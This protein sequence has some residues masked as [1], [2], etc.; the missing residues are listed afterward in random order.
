MK[1]EEGAVRPLLTIA[2]PTYNRAK[3]LAGLLNVLLPQVADEPR[4]ELLICD[5]ASPDETEAVVRGWM[6]GGAPVRYIRHAENIGSDANF[7]RCFEE[8]RGEYFWLFGDDDVVLPGTV[9]KVLGHLERDQWDML[10]VTGYEFKEDYERERVEDKLG[11]RWHTIENERELMRVVNVMFTLI[12]VIVVNKRR[13]E[14]IAHEA[15]RELVGTNLVQLSWSLPLL[16]H[17]RK[18]L[19][20]WERM[21]AGRLGNAGGYSVGKVFG[22]RLKEVAERTMPGRA[23]LVDEL[24]NCTL[25]R[26]FPR[27]LY[28][29]RAAGNTRLG[30]HEVGDVLEKCFGRNFR[31]W[32][33]VYPVL[34]LPMNMAKMWVKAGMAMSHAVYMLTV[35][36]FWSK[37]R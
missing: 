31:Y 5:N 27:T 30:M 15:P 18:S 13:L 34:K 7:V 11:R 10:Y 6:E 1:S 28:E 33:F 26:W 36:R 37:E 4:V 20:V 3:L 2:I 17:H 32:L 21:I 25:R 22:E 8:A 24:M 16:L 23:D 19:V 12:S 9:A 14:A 35:P 29:A